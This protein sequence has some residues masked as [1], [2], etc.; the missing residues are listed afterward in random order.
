MDDDRNLYLALEKDNDGDARVFQIEM[1]SKFWKTDD[2]ADAHDIGLIVPSFER[3]NHPINGIQYVSTL[4]KKGALVAAARNDNQ[5]WVV[6]LD[7]ETPTKVIDLSF[8][9]PTKGGDPKSKG[10]CAALELMDNASIEGVAVLNT[11]LWLINDPWK[12]NYEKN[13]QCQ[14]NE[15]RYKGMSPLLFSLPIESL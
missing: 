8:W 5:L 13:I 1:D 12:L 2:F 7:K 9:A 11:K 15:S 10:Q 6:Y 14:S 4:G 3:G